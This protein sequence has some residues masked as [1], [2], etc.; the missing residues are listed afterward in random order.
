MVSGPGPLAVPDLTG[1]IDVSGAAFCD[2]HQRSLGGISAG[3]GAYG[4]WGRPHRTGRPTHLHEIPPAH[5][6]GFLDRVPDMPI[7]CDRCARPTDPIPR[8]KGHLPGHVW[9]PPPSEIP[10]AGTD[11]R[12]L[13][14]VGHFLPCLNP[15]LPDQTGA[16]GTAGCRVRSQS[17]TV[18]R[19]SRVASF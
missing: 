19:G 18:A 8:A 13:W 16:H 6:E 3:R 4:H 9:L 2:R 11:P 5:L 10:F 14:V 1:C 7:H 12:P 15:S 17:D